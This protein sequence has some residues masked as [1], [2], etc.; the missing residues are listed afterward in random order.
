LP[1]ARAR[2]IT[3]VYVRVYTRAGLPPPAPGAIVATMKAKMCRICLME[4]DDEI[5][6]A[7]VDVHLWF[8]QQVTLSFDDEPA[9]PPPPEQPLHVS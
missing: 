3:E 6:A 7:T 9:V 8:H 4:H 5:H 2:L 1:S